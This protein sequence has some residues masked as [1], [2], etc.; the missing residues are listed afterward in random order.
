MGVLDRLVLSDTAWERMAPLIIGR[1]DQR[2]STGRDNRMFVEGVLWIVRTGSPWRDLPEVFGEWNS[3]LIRQI[4]DVTWV[5][6]NDKVV[7][8]GAVMENFWDRAKPLPAKGPIM[9]Q[10]HGGEIRWRN[11]YVKE[12]SAAESAELMKKADAK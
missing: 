1:P 2:G 8:D 7:V 5:W 3:V 11:I 12:L 6:L 9:L 10:T 4:G